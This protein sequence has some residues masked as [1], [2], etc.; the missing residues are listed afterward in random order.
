[1]E[2]INRKNLLLLSIILLM[3]ILA[4]LAFYRQKMAM[5]TMHREYQKTIKNMSRSQQLLWNQCKELKE[6]CPSKVAP[7]TNN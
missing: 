5:Y 3:A 4:A 1:M 6:S 7:V 2:K